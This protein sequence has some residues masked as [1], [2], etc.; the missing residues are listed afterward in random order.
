MSIRPSNR[1]LSA[2]PVAGRL[3]RRLRCRWWHSGKTAF[4]QP[5][6]A[7]LNPQNIGPHLLPNNANRSDVA[8]REDWMGDQLAV[9]AKTPQPMLI[10]IGGRCGASFIDRN[11]Q[12]WLRSK[13]GEVDYAKLA[14][15]SPEDQISSHTTSPAMA[16]IMRDFEKIKRSFGKSGRREENYVALPHGY[17]VQDNRDAGIVD[18]EIEIR[19]FRLDVV[20]DRTEAHRRQRRPPEHVQAMCGPDHEIDLKTANSNQIKSSFGKGKQAGLGLIPASTA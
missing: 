19:R 3:L 11:F 1:L 8:G 18:G 6:G 20:D 2:D 5:H 15:E 9:A 4:V 13:L 14:P 16:R 12:A 10:E 7:L 17:G